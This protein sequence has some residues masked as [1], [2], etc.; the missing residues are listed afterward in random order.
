MSIY[1]QQ[2]SQNLP[3]VRVVHKCTLNH[4]YAHCYI[5]NVHMLNEQPI[6]L[7]NKLL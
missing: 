5:F 2:S 4:K 7:P 3:N 6:N 1:C